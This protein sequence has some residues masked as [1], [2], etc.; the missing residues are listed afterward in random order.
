MPCT[1]PPGGVDDEQRDAWHRRRV[2]GN[3]GD[4]SGE[5]LAHILEAAV[6]VATHVVSV[7]P[8]RF[9][10]V[11]RRAGG[12]HAGEPWSEALDLRLDRRR[13]VAGGAV[14]DV[15]VGPCGMSARRSPRRVEAAG[16]HE[17]DERLLG[18]HAGSD[19]GLAG[20]QLVERPPRCMVP[21]R[22][23]SGAVHG[24]GPL[25]AQSSLKMP[26]P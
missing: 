1:P 6:D 25:S 13:H 19:G 16:L 3:A 7:A 22:P 2:G 12:D 23:T 14:W 26:G 15:A 4:R 21:A 17:E 20:H 24:I 8:L 10:A 9:G 5:Q 11:H 18:T